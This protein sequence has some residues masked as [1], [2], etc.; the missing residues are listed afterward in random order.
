MNQYAIQLKDTPFPAKLTRLGIA[1]LTAG[2]IAFVFGGIGHPSYWWGGYLLGFI[3]VMGL[4]VTLMFFVALSYLVNAG[5]S[6]AIRRIPELL[7]TFVLF[8]PVAAVPLIIGA[9]TGNIYEWMHTDD[10]HLRH[11][12]KGVYLSE[13]FFWTRVVFYMAVWI[14][15]YRVII[16]NSLRQ[17]ST[18]DLTPTQRNWKLAAP[19]VLL[20]A[21]TI[22]FAS[23]DLVMSLEPHWF[24]TIFGVYSFAGHFV[25]ALSLIML[26]M[27]M[28]DKGGYLKGIINREHYHDVGKLMFAFTVFW[29]YVA[30]SQYFIIWYG[31]LPEETVFFAKRLQNGWELFGWASLFVHF[32]IPF[33]F[34]LRQDVKRRPQLVPIGGIILLIAHAIDLSWVILPVFS[35]AHGEAYHLS[36]ALVLCGWGA[37]VAMLGALLFVA[38]RAFAKHSAVAFNDPYLH[39]SLEYHTGAY[40]VA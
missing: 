10:P 39:E 27:R 5:W 33:L 9:V 40:D 22:T 17:D 6:A 34:L 7:S 8:L 26:T 36:W 14:I 23:F 16:G 37:I 29:T 31:N 19:F 1:L 30:F 21:L 38:A 24:S 20:Y 2:I 3:Y 15:M 32:V 25:A 11:G 35:A 28:L 18:A 4:S 13:P 12:F